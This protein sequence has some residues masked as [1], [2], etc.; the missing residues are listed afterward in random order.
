MPLNNLSK[1]RLRSYIRYEKYRVLEHNLHLLEDQWVVRVGRYQSVTWRESV[2]TEPRFIKG[3]FKRLLI[4][5]L[6]N[7]RQ[8]AL[9]FR[10]LPNDKY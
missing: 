5:K 9:T 3:P 8:A 2:A 4:Y 10:V 1:I 7:K 6:F